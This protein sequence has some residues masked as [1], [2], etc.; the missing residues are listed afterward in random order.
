MKMQTISVFLDTTKFA[1]FWRKIA[2]ISRTRGGGGLSCD[3]YIF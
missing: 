2:D 1:D 3:P